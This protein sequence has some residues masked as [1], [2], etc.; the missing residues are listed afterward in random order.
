MGQLDFALIGNCQVSALLDKRARYVWA[1]MPRFDSPAVFASL[2]GNEDNGIWSSLPDTENYETRQ[3]YVNN[4]NVL[5]TEFHLKG[6]E[7]F[8]I[9]DFAPRYPID[10]GYYRPSQ[11]IR[12]IQPVKGNPRIRVML[13]PKFEYGKINPKISYISN[14]IVC[15]AFGRRLF[16]Q[17]NIPCAYFLDAQ[18][19]ELAQN[20]YYVLSHGEPF[21]Q[22]LKFGCEDLLD[23]T[24]SYW[25]TWVKQCNIPLEYQD[26]VIRSALVLKLHIYEDTGAIIAATTTSI[27][28]SPDG[29]RTWDYRFCWLR[30]AYFVINVLN[31]LGHFEEMEHFI[32]F[33]YNIAL[34]EPGGELQPVYGIGGE[35]VITEKEL[36]WLSG[37]MGIGPVRTGNAA[38]SLAQFDV[39]GEM[40]LA[41]TPLF[42][43]SRLGRC[44]MD[45]KKAFENVKN[46]IEHA[47]V[48]FNQP[49][50][51]I[52]EFRSKKG[53]HVFSKLLS[54]AAVDRGIKI[55]ERMGQKEFYKT[56][57]QLRD[58]MRAEIEK[59]GWNNDL[60]YY[61]QSYGDHN[62]DA[63]NLLMSEFN[64]H[65]P[66]SEMFRSM[67]KTYETLLMKNGFV[68]RYQNQ[69]D[70]GIP[71]HAFTICTFW[72]V[73]ALASIG[74]K[75]EARNI[76]E[77]ILSKANH[78]GLLSE[79]ID[80]VTGEL[81]GNLPQAYSH[82]GIINSA[83]RLSDRF[84]KV[85]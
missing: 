83:F 56:W 78:L 17:S 63:S 64:F 12:M 18:P 44:Q 62:P 73:D 80:P 74:R 33:L 35:R 47:I 68:F 49:D 19:F 53:H 52:W 85:L 29:G 43:D 30:D 28:E 1:C 24:T 71:Q 61:T 50:S 26:V 75:E 25:R 5:L 11:F 77:N 58:N 36:P 20:Q 31:Q 32:Q 54:W 3:S 57:E 46:L 8:N 34:S 81:W 38:Y 7:Q 27:P 69:D 37:F 13:K 66:D 84:H 39:Y 2:L 59:M 22:P 67:V 79:D 72:M 6:G 10:D 15:K 16:F 48:V 60:G 76:F 4:T 70:F 40:V 82:V 45:L 42:F 55:A 14:G 51:G 23:R 21:N 65:N 9:I 41:F